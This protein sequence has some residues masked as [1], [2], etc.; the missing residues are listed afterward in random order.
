MRHFF[1]ITIRNRNHDRTTHGDLTRNKDNN[2]IPHNI[3][4]QG[5]LHSNLRG[6]PSQHNVQKCT[7]STLLDSGYTN[8]RDNV[9]S[10]NPNRNLNR[11]PPVLLSFSL[12]PPLLHCRPKWQGRGQIMSAKKYSNKLCILREINIYLEF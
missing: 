2:P 10:R 3:H 12:P 4:V 6:V 1:F 9:H 7:L 11:R 5:R 8:N